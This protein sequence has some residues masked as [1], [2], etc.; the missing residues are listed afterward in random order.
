MFNTAVIQGRQA[1]R[2]NTLI[3]QLNFRSLAH[4]LACHW[5]SASELSLQRLKQRIRSKSQMRL[6]AS[7]WVWFAV[8]ADCLET[9]PYLLADVF[10]QLSHRRTS[11]RRSF[12]T[13]VFRPR[14][15]HCTDQTIL[16][17]WCREERGSSP[18]LDSVLQARSLLSQHGEI[19]VF[20]LFWKWS[21]A[22]SQQVWILLP[23]LLL[24]WAHF[25]GNQ[26]KSRC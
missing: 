14:A 8:C 22:F 1:G 2:R 4:H 21:A 23:R 26:P 11:A 6:A 15:T 7:L 25:G 12:P 19:D 13:H 3:S 9:I 24:Q 20:F 10:W 17:L 5:S 18:L 16:P